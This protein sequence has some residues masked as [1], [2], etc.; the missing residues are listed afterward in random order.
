MNMSSYNVYRCEPCNWYI[1][2]QHVMILSLKIQCSKC[3]QVMDHVNQIDI[4]TL[5]ENGW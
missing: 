2:A 1:D 5:E 4:P 3:S